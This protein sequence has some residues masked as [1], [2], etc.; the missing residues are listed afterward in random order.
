LNAARGELVLQERGADVGLSIL[1]EYYD[2]LPHR[3]G[4]SE[5]GKVS[6]ARMKRALDSYR[7]KVIG[8]YNEG[9][10]QRL[11]HSPCERTR[12]A[13]VLALGLCGTMESNPHLARMLHDDDHAVRQ[14]TTDALWNLWFRGAGDEALHE[15]QRLVRTTSFEKQISDLDALLSRYPDFAEALN[16][17]AIAYF[18]AGEWRKS[19]ADCEAALKLNPFH[20]GALSGLAQCALKLN[21]PHRALQAFR[22]ALAINPGLE[23]V[24]DTIRALEQSLSEE[25]ESDIE[26]A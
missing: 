20:F 19:I 2:E 17:R 14:M 5:K 11:L 13:A 12:R 23:G 6:V 9:T 4:R 26:P 22:Q 7:R 24:R 3:G 18:R 1:V 16:Q 21:Q 25:G 15:L 10:L 8:R